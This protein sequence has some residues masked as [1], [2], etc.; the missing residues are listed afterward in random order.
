MPLP[1]AADLS[2]GEAA[3][4]RVFCE[5]E[6]V[7]GSDVLL[8]PRATPAATGGLNQ[9]GFFVYTPMRTVDG[10]EVVVNRGWVPK[11]SG[12]PSVVVWVVWSS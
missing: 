8:G 3:Y 11:V 10:T 1:E 9:S 2:A 6:F 7:P 5:G 4:R 12:W